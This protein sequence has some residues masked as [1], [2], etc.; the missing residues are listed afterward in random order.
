MAK[1]KQPKCA[2]GAAFI[3]LSVPSP[4][5]IGKPAIITLWSMCILVLSAVQVCHAG[6]LEWRQRQDQWCVI[7]LERQAC[8]PDGMEMVAFFDFGAE[9]HLPVDHGR[10]IAMFY[11][12]E[13]SGT[14]SASVLGDTF[15][16]IARESIGPLELQEYTTQ[17]GRRQ[18]SQLKTFAVLLPNKFMVHFGGL[19][20]DQ[21]RGLAQDFAAQWQQPVDDH[22]SH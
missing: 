13:A 1:I 20:S 3:A 2:C 7:S 9:F 5:G 8:L 19:D 4:H 16:L 6:D 22:Q 17:V 18:S 11:G 21:V 12:I 14:Q 15:E 10:V